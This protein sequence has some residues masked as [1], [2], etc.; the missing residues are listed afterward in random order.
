MDDEGFRAFLAQ[1]LGRRSIDSYLSNARRIETALS[2][3]LAAADLS[4]VGLS[5]L[6]YD[7]SAPEHGISRAKVANCLTAARRYAE[8][9]SGHNVPPFAEPATKA[10]ARGLSITPPPRQRPVAMRF[11]T[12]RELLTD[13][14]DILEELRDRKIVRTGNSPVGDYAETLFAKAFGWTLAANS[15]A[16]YDARNADDETTYQIKCRRVTRHNGSRQ[17]SAIRRLPEKTFNVL[18]AVLLDEDFS[19]RRAALIPHAIVVA[20]ARRT[21][22]TNSWR[23]LLEDRVWNIA[24]VRDVTTELEDAAA[25]L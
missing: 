3:D 12:V 8:Y 5:K 25:N 9:A 23:F 6:R 20:L 13:Y 21:D 2:I 11:T 17:L 18:A 7:L 14:A 22:H 15:A 1:R 4:N 10:R 24:G 19:V 16:G